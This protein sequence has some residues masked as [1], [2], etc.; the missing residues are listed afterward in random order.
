[1]LLTAV[2]LSTASAFTQA[3]LPAALPPPYTPQE[4][5]RIV[6]RVALYPDPLLAQVLAAATYAFQIPDA[7]RWADA[8][9]YLSD[10]G[11]SQAMA[12]D[13]FPRYAGSRPIEAHQLNT[14]TA[15]G[16]TGA[17]GASESLNG[18]VHAA[19]PLRA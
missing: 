3:P 16:A 19:D 8:H 10:S 14:P 17:P 15:H 7:A 18:F 9:S 2:M 13:Q 6:V 5:D 4:L 11:L 12:E 1:M